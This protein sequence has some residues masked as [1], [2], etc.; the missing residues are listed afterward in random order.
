MSKIDPKKV[1]EKVAR[2]ADLLKSAREEAGMRSGEI[3]KLKRELAL[4]EDIIQGN[5]KDPEVVPKLLASLGAL[6]NLL[7]L[8][9]AL[10]EFK[11]PTSFDV[12][13]LPKQIEVSNFPAKSSID[14]FPKSFE[15]SNFPDQIK[16]QVEFPETY[17]VKGWKD[18]IAELGLIKGVIA[19]LAELKSHIFKAVVSGK[20]FIT[21]NDPSEAVPVRLTTA[22]ARAFYNAM[23]SVVGSGG[24]D[25]VVTKLNAILAAIQAGSS[26][27]STSVGDGTA[28]VTVAGT[29]VQLSSVSI[30]RVL[31][32]AHESNT[33]TLVVGG[34]TCVAA[35]VGRR[36]TALFATQSQ[37]FQVSNLNLLY[38][39]STVSGDKINYYYEV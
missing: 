8:L 29:R 12:G 6:P 18:L 36:G 35:L 19:G 30:K 16:A 4:A 15:V 2:L 10:S 13:N 28:T 5:L 7:Q 17:R 14:N 33:G 3:K 34:A 31:I 27:G 22:D 11:L 21:N 9:K 37:L 39:D 38:I 20:V 24:D 23:L 32:Q 1:E 26:G 25:N